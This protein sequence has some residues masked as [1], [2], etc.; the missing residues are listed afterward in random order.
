[1]PRR[2]QVTLVDLDGN[3]HRV[4]VDAESVYEAAVL[5]IRAFMKAGF[6]ELQ[7]GAASVLEVSV[8]KPAVLHKVNVGQVERWL[9]LALSNPSQELSGSDSPLCSAASA[10][11]RGLPLNMS[12]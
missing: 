6:M 12:G 8:Q 7:P 11:S 5:A 3:E 10:Y 1:M 9:S 2:C 4:R